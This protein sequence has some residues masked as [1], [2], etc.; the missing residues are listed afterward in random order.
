MIN[1]TWQLRQKMR[2]NIVAHKTSRDLKVY[3]NFALSAK[4][5][6][7]LKLGITSVFEIVGFLKHKTSFCSFDQGEISIP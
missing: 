3:H 2:N 4:G 6:A 5:Y 7:S 1:I